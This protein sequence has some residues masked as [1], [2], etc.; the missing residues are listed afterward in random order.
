M[1]FPLALSVSYPRRWISVAHN[2]RGFPRSPF[3]CN[4]VPSYPSTPYLPSLPHT[5][6]DHKRVHVPFQWPRAMSDGPRGLWG[7]HGGLGLRLRWN[8]RVRW[9]GLLQKLPPRNRSNRASASSGGSRKPTRWSTLFSPSSQL[10]AAPASIH[11][12]DLTTTQTQYQQWPKYTS[13]QNEHSR[14]SPPA[15]RPAFRGSR[16]WRAAQA[17]SWYNQPSQFSHCRAFISWPRTS[18]SG[19]GD[20]GVQQHHRDGGGDCRSSCLVHPHTPVCH[21][22]ISEQRWRILSSRP[23]PQLHQ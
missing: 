22:Q 9:R 19:G 16:T 5:A 14:S 15:T 10:P 18:R 6:R 23:E 13:G 8:D 2:N 1:L 21:V 20:P 12:H 3:S 4:K 7:G 17:H 11:P